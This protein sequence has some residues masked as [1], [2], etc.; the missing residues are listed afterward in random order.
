[1]NETSA[2]EHSMQDGFAVGEAMISRRSWTRFEIGEIDTGAKMLIATD[3]RAIAF[4]DAQRWSDPCQQW[5][6]TLMQSADESGC[7]IHDKPSHEA[8]AWSDSLVHDYGFVIE[9]SAV[10]IRRYVNKTTGQRA[11][12]M[13]IETPT[14][15]KATFVMRD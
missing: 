7:I 15:L 6:R 3:G 11:T 13:T 9:G 5:G 12:L 8:E 14:F 10:D 1:M 2:T 4:D